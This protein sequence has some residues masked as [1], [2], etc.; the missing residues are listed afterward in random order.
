MNSSDKAL[1]PCQ[2]PQMHQQGCVSG[3]QKKSKGPHEATLRHPRAPR[4]FLMGRWPPR[5]FILYS[6]PHTFCYFLLFPHREHVF[7][8]KLKEKQ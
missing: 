2:G 1:L 7:C 8:L 4:P 5:H 3:E 6:P